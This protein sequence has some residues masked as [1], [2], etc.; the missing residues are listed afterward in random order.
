MVQAQAR[1][2]DL[3]AAGKLAAELNNQ[4]PLDTLVKN[5]WLPSIRAA[6]EI[7]R[8]NPSKAIEE[9][10]S[11]ESYELSTAFLTQDTLYPAYLR[12]QAYMLLHKGN[13]ATAEF[14]KIID[15]RGLVLNFPL[16]ALAHLG[17]ARAYSTQGDLQNTMS[18]VNC[19]VW[20]SPRVF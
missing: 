7:G 20:Q 8:R 19:C 15:H 12:G 18:S 4:F 16:G 6:V 3:V 10:Q 1:G 17:L 13:E 9:L 14:Q 2:G 5:Y 11:T